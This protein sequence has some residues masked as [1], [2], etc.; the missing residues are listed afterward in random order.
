MGIEIRV[1]GSR[2]LIEFCALWP[3]SMLKDSPLHLMI[4]GFGV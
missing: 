2:I 1:L 4:W 3:T